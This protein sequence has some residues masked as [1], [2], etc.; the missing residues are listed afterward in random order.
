MHIQTSA[1]GQPSRIVFRVT[2]ML[3][4]V[5][6]GIQCVWLLAAE[7]ARTDVTQLPTD[8]PSAAL[9]AKQRDAA[10]RASSFAFFRGDLWAE[11]AF[12][13]A[14]LVVDEKP[15]SISSDLTGAS[16]RAR[17]SLDRALDGA[18]VQ[19]GAWLLLAGLALRYPPSDV[20]PL[21]ALKMSY[22]TGPSERTLIPLRLRTAA[23]ADQFDDLEMREL[24]S[25]DLR[26][27]LEQKQ[28]APMT[29][30]YEIASARGKQFIEQ[31]VGDIDPSI[32]DALRA[33]ATPPQLSLPN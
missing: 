17:S 25:R 8:S 18:P 12:T 13:Y 33:R 7:L 26:F 2:T 21:D 16:A 31:T 28:I 11:S 1:A 20:T 24:V 3:F 29:E 6:L 19:S 30:A 23:Q 10:L 27:L 4:A 9:A 22:Y 15:T 5:L 32:R 14:F